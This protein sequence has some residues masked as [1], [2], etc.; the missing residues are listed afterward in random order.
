MGKTQD[1]HGE[2]IAKALEKLADEYKRANDYK[3]KE[4]Q[5]KGIVPGPG[6]HY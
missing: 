2:R 3:L 5:S 6:G 1:D 4:M